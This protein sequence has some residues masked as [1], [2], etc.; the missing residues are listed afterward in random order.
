MSEICEVCQCDPCDCN[1]WG[2]YEFWGVVPRRGE[3]K[4]SDHNMAGSSNR[5][6]PKPHSQMEDE[7][8]QP[9]NRILFVDLYNTGTGSGSI[10][11]YSVG[12]G[13]SSNG[14]ENKS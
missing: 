5:S 3:Q 14:S 10:I 12:R 11:M 9:Q 2:V 7:K 4:R 6:S 8:Q 1:D 13:C